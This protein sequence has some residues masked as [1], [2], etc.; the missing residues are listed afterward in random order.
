LYRNYEHD[1]KAQARLEQ[2]LMLHPN[3]SRND[4][5]MG[6]W[7][8]RVTDNAAENAR[9]W[10]FLQD[11]RNLQGTP[12]CR[13]N[14]LL[15]RVLGNAWLRDEFILPGSSAKQVRW[16]QAAVKA[17]RQQ[18]DAFLERLLLLIHITSGQPA[19]GTEILSIRCVNTVKGYY[20]SLFV[21]NGMVSTVTTYHKGYNVN[22]TLLAELD[23]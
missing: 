4:L 21:D 17:Y 20:R 14:W 11:P 12:P 8:H 10:S 6:F 2:L 18:I 3:E 22:G 1:G 7:M 23:F 15:E 19:R 5:G 9:D 16:N 13:E